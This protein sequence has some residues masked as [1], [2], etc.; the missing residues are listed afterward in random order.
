MPDFGET[1]FNLEEP[2]LT[3]GEAVEIT[4]IPSKTLN[5]WTQREVV[6]LGQMHRTGRRLY[7]IND[8]VELK[9]IGS[10]AEMVQMPPAHAAAVAKWARQRSM[11]MTERDASGNP[12]HRGNKHTPR[13]SL[14]VWFDKGQHKIDLEVGDDWFSKHSFPFPFIVVPLDDIVHRVVLD[15]FDVLEREHNKQHGE[16]E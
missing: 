12:K 7:S 4:G 1:M 11:E 16:G 6:N 2:M 3:R 5:N 15:A 9:I 10:L 8:L 14:R 13:H